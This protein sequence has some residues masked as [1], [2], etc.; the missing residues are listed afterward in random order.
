MVCDR[1]KIDELGCLGAPDWIIE[2]LSAKTRKKDLT[3]KR[4]LYTRHR[5]PLYWLISPAKRTITALKLADD[6][7]YK[8]DGALSCQGRMPV[9]EYPGLEID[10]DWVF[11][12]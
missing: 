5:V 8:S 2:V 4:D 3:E 7:K 10:W 6:G 1:S 12:E 11:S 9:P